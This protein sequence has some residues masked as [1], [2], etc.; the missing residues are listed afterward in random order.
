MGSFLEGGVESLEMAKAKVLEETSKKDALNAA[1]ASVKAKEKEL[2]TLKKNMDDKIASETKEKRAA[3]KKRHDDLV[4]EANKGLKEAEKKRKD[5]KTAAV[6]ERVRTE[7]GNLVSQNGALKAQNETLFR[8]GGVPQFCNSSFY[9]SLFAPK[10]GKNFLV[11][12]IC[13]IIALGVI[14]NIVCLC[15]KSTTIVKILVYLVIVVVFAGI[16]ALISIATKAKGKAAVIERGRAN[17]E[18]IEK[19]KK[20]IKKMA[21]GIKADKDESQY[22]L[23][24]FDDEIKSAQEMVKAKAADRDA[25]FK[26]FE[27]QT[28]PTIR[29]E[30]ETTDLPAITQMEEEFKKMQDEFDAQKADYQVFSQAV[31]EDCTQYL[32]KDNMDVDKLDGMIYLLKNGKVANIREAIEMIKGEVK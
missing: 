30:I 28:A 29:K 12:A 6:N 18:Q 3:L 21:R 20:E 24:T 27:E 15:L 1:E 11:F 32:G 17:I 16:Y 2:Q 4:D 19:N 14:P 25:A 9:Y 10:S 13:A 8:A 22:G 7:T 31:F 23:E 26:E 5:A